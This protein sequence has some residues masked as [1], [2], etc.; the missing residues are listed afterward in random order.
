MSKTANIIKFPRVII[1]HLT[2][3]ETICVR[4][5]IVHGTNDC[6]PLKG[7][8]EEFAAWRESQAEI[9]AEQAFRLNVLEPRDEWLAAMPE[10]QKSIIIGNLRSAWND[11]IAYG[12]AEWAW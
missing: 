4:G 11:G 1:A 7:K 6:S 5:T 8:E 3:H 9:N 10:P 2:N 12:K